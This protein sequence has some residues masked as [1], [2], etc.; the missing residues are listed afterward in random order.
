MFS[1]RGQ[2]MC[3]TRFQAWSFRRES[4]RRS[5]V[6]TEL[7]GVGLV[8]QPTQYSTSVCTLNLRAMPRNQ[9]YVTMVFMAFSTIPR[10]SN[11]IFNKSLV[12]VGTYHTL[13]IETGR[14][15]ALA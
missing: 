5:T 12:E 2:Q 9:P 1:K 6:T 3:Q 14:Q 8:V 10:S 4:I 7:F 11:V 15:Q 13:E